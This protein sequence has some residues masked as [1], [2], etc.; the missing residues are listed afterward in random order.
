MPSPPLQSETHRQLQKC[1]DASLKRNY[2][3]CEESVTNYGAFVTFVVL[4][5]HQKNVGLV[6]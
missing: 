1:L 5:V 4:V 6:E 3:I 2:Q